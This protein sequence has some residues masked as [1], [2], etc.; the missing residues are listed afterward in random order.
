MRYPE[1]L[2]EKGTIGF[3]APSFGCAT[4]PYK[5]AFVNAQSK[6]MGEGYKLLLGPNCYE[7][8]GIGIS[9]DPYECGLELN[10]FYCGDDADVLISC[11]GGELMN[12]TIDYVDFAAIAKARPKWFMGY[13][14]NAHFTF[15]L[16]T[17]C[18]TAAIYGPN[19]SSFGMEPWHDAIQDAF[20]LL[21]GRKLKFSGYD[22][23]E[24]ESKK[25]AEHPLEPYN[26]AVKSTLHTF[27]M[28]N[29]AM[30]GRLLGG[31][32]DILNNL[33]GTKYDKVAEFTDR[34]KNDGILWFME[35]CEMNVLDI[36]RCLWHMDSAGWFRNATGFII[37][38]PMRFGQPM[39]GLDQYEAVIG[40]LGKYGVPILMDAD[41]GHLP[42]SIPIISG[43]VADVL[44]RD[45]SYTIEYKLL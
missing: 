42:P 7:D 34:Y 39:M 36:R 8:S 9:N 33:V 40:V 1:F 35:S 25:D 23:W 32:M 28:K 13:S 6:L 10:D 14:D 29:G 3:V 37:G 27:A 43:A 12:E 17:L 21:R 30:H 20:D 11:G 31:C 2:Q 44:V 19:A 22:L 18:D 45:N 24:L 4:E 15:L 38:R 16:T 26:A 41:I 5:T